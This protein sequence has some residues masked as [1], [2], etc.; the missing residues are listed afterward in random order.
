MKKKKYRLRL[1]REKSIPEQISWQREV[2]REEWLE[3]KKQIE[4]KI[5]GIRT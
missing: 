3:T 4:S 2:I 5:R 1:Q